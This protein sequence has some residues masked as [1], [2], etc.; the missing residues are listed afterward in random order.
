[1]KDPVELKDMP[2]W[3]R[4]NPHLLADIID[5]FSKVCKLIR[6]MVTSKELNLGSVAQLGRAV[7]SKTIGRG[8]ESSHSRNC[9]E[10]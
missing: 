6:A 3:A 5:K 1:M 2:I 9:K 4:D 8:F 7:V 10:G